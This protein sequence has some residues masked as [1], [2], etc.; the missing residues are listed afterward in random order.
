[1]E[2]G[3]TAVAA[4]ARE[5]EEELGIQARIGHEVGRHVHYYPRRA[6]IQLAFYAV[7]EFAG[8]PQSIAFESIVWESPERLTDYDFLEGDLGFVKQLAAGECDL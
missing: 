4:L 6:T 8:E 5:L 7:K 1:M 3:E 2:R